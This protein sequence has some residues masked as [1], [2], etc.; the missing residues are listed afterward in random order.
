ML[1]ILE[2]TENENGVG[3]TFRGTENEDF[4]LAQRLFRYAI[5]VNFCI[6]SSFGYNE[7]FEE[8]PIF[9]YPKSTTITLVYNRELGKYGATWT[10]KPKKSSTLD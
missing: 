2:L 10:K 6:D 8:I 1:K 3:L 5:S 4:L 9:R 7:Y